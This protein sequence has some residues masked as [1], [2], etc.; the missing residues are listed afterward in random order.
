[1]EDKTLYL[2][3][4]SGISGDMTVA[5]L[6][7]LGANKETLLSALDSLNIQGF[8]IRIG[9]TQKCGIDACDFDVILESEEEHS[10][11]HNMPAVK[12]SVSSSSFKMSPG[13]KAKVSV[14]KHSHAHRNLQDINQIIDNSGITSNAKR[15]AKKIFEVVAIAEAKAHGLGINEVHFHEVGAVDSIVDIVAVAVCIDNLGIKDVI[16]S[17]MYEGTGHV[18]CQHG[19]L[20]VPV[21]AVLNILSANSLPIKVT[22]TV[23][24]MITPTGAAIAAALRTRDSLPDKYTIKGI[25]LGA[26]KKDFPKANVLRAY[27]IEEAKSSKTMDQVWLLETN[28]DDCTGENL[29]YV[30]E[31]LLSEGAKDVYYTPIFMKKNRPA[32]K[33]SIICKDADKMRLEAIVFKNTTSI[34]IRSIK[35]ERNILEREN[36]DIM[37]EFG[38]IRVKATTF[39]GEKFYSPEYE[40]IRSACLN[41]NLSYNEVYEKIMISIMGKSS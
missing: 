34:G 12:K 37:T 10:H 39:D 30:M 33:L 40:D 31:K 19:I 41:H 32:Y 14:Q 13:I 27:L 23:G 21:P 1:M 11:S 7:D 4:F 15:M 18:R 24:E 35:M 6:L 17:E 2:E 28:L 22:D 36:M 20:P 5:A 3:C 25:G 29:G 38:R 8:K 16:V 26:G 9:R